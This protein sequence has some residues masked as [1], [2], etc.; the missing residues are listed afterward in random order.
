MCLEQLSLLLP[1][2]KCKRDN[3]SYPFGNPRGFFIERYSFDYSQ[4]VLM[5]MDFS[6]ALLITHPKKTVKRKF[7]SKIGKNI[8]VD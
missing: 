2:L 5:Q 3:Y 4:K 6:S 8:D 7:L 1:D